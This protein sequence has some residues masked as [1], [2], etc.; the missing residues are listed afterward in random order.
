MLS[1]F[2]L[3][4]NVNWVLEFHCFFGN[5]KLSRF[6]KISNQIVYLDYDVALHTGDLFSECV[7]NYIHPLKIDNLNIKS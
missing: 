7:K 3:Q 2:L 5:A 6:L 4:C 1:F